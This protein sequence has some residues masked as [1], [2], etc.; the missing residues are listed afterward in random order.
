VPVP[1]TGQTL[2]GI[3]WG[4]A[5]LQT[6]MLAVVDLQQRVPPKGPAARSATIGANWKE[7]RNIVMRSNRDNSVS[8]RRLHRRTLLGQLAA[9]FGAVGIGLLGAASTSAPVLAATASRTSAL[10]TTAQSGAKIITIGEWQP[11]SIMNTL[12]TSEGGNV[13]SGTKLAL[14]GLLTTDE[15]GAPA[16]ELASDVPTLQNGGISADG[17]TI[18][19]KLRPS[20]TWHDG[21]PVTAADVQYTW[22]AI[23]QP[24]HNVATRYGYD[25]ISAVD[26]PDPQ[27]VVVRF[28]DPF[29]PWATLFDIVLPQHILATQSDFNGS[30]YHQQPVGFGPFKV[31]E[32]IKGDHTT[33]DAFEGYW[34]SR[35]KIDRLFIRYFGNTDAELQALQAKEI[36]LAWGVPLSSIPQLQDLSNQGI[37][38]LVQPGPAQE[39]YAFNMD[40][41]QVPM[42]G[43]VQLRKALALAA[44]RQ[45]IV[46]Q[47]LF[48]LTKIARG[49]WDNTPWENTNIAPDPYDPDQAKA[50]LDS[51]G[52]VPGSDGIR[53][54][55][56]QRLSFDNTTTSGNQLRENVQLLV[57]QN[58]KDIGVEMNIKNMPTD[59]LFGSYS[60][61]GVWA[62]GTYQMG[63]WTTGINLPDPDLSSRYLCSQIASEQN[64]AGGQSYRYCNPQVDALFTAQATEL[65]AT[66]RK[67]LFD[68]IQQITH[69]D[70]MSVWL[71]DSTAAW[72]ALTRVKNFENTVRAP[73][74]GFHWR[75]EDWDVA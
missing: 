74:G 50:I 27:T 9:T 40:H 29:A 34:R 12:M 64:P 24:D 48:G 37:T 32:N 35:P 41:T 2:T 42:F 36:D 31:T 20:V 68:Q 63:G 10:R 1:P 62:R 13:I 55:G 15:G 5:I 70:Y 16:P 26:T 19:Y 73:F 3:G 43:D 51:L 54:K 52:W 53:Q 65:D 18:T 11:V 72:G 49:D 71:Y 33:Y 21:Q 14:R 17:K 59:Q 7:Y 69:D 25:R 61:G 47:L 67:A 75:A 38:T 28:N 30:P 60:A 4:V 6:T 46:N 58:F 23:M 56:G 22:Q 8:A 44:D 57:Q 66:K 39:R 45:T